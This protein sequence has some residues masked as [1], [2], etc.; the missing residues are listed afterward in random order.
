MRKKRETTRRPRMGARL[1]LEVRDK[2]PNYVYRWFNDDGGRINE[3]VECGWEYVF[4]EDVKLDTSGGKPGLGSVASLSVDKH[5]DG[6]PKSAYLL[7]I[8]KEWY[9]EDQIEKQKE[10]DLVDQSIRSGTLST[11]PNAY[12]PGQA[13]A[14]ITEDVAR[15]KR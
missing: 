6:S 10:T 3:A 11:V 5:A 7:R 4:K 12:T 13:S 15:I 2:D 1:K 14:G 9:D 8:R